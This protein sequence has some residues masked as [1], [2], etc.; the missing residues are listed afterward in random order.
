M[1]VY[2]EWT[3]ASIAA[4]AQE[5]SA[6]DLGRDYDRLSIEIPLM[7]S[8]KLSLQVAERI[9]G[10]YYNLGPNS[11]ATENETFNRA[12]VWELGGFRF[13]KV[14][15]SQVQSAER[16]IRIKGTRY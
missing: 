1:S 3:A 13:I 11:T 15:A 5:S 2:G 12:D 9:G 4:G 7:D 8:C 16:L 14:V 10:T 6:I